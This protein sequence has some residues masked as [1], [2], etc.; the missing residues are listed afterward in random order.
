MTKKDDTFMDM[1]AHKL[2]LMLGGDPSLL[3]ITLIPGRNTCIIISRN[4]TY[5]VNSLRV[6]VKEQGKLF[7]YTE[8]NLPVLLIL[9]RENF[10][11]TPDSFLAVGKDCMLIWGSA[12]PDVELDLTAF[13]TGSGDKSRILAVRA[14]FPALPEGSERK[15]SDGFVAIARDPRIIVDWGQRIKSYSNTTAH[16]GADLHPVEYWSSN[17]HGEPEKTAP[18]E[19]Q[20]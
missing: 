7:E 12:L 1:I 8:K 15:N 11:E 3:I 5:I 2:R 16:S 6:T 20:A 13:A 10:A 9:R 17:E 4:H 14:Y 18:E 19:G